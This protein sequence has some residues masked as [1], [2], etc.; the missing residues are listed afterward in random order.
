[1]NAVLMAHFIV[2]TIDHDYRVPTHL[3]IIYND[4]KLMFCENI[5]LL[6]R[7]FEDICGILLSLRY[8][9]FEALEERV[10]AENMPA[11]TASSSSVSPLPKFPGRI[12]VELSD[13]LPADDITA[14]VVVFKYH[15]GA[16]NFSVLDILQQPTVGMF[17]LSKIWLGNRN[18]IVDCKLVVD[19]KEI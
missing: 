8:M 1:M 3:D 11:V 6:Y 4:M 13:D 10:A 5:S 9:K 16:L 12:T 17:A 2:M 14:V 19:R 7:K 18:E 15:T